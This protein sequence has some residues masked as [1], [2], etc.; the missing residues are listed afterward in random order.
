MAEALLTIPEVARE[1]GVSPAWVRKWLLAD[2]GRRQLPHT[3]V[4]WGER[5]VIRFSR[6]DLEAIRALHPMSVS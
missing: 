6:A 1:L 4:L 2:K 5:E 3:R